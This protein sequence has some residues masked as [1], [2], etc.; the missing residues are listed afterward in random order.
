VTALFEFNDP[1]DSPKP[2]LAKS[3]ARTTDDPK[4]LSDL[5]RLCRVGR[6]YDV[7]RWIQA[8]R[9]LQ[10][11]SG[12]TAGQRR[13]AS[14]LEIALQAGNQSL[15]FLLLCN[16]YDPNLEVG[17][18]LDLM[19]CLPLAQQFRGRVR[20]KTDGTPAWPAQTSD[21]HARNR[22]HCPMRSIGVGHSTSCQMRSAMAAASASSA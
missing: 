5:H 17:S 6:L 1:R 19:A 12:G 3:A 15:V 7:E 8:G 10:A 14:A 21:R 20:G 22:W 16:G 18:P 13:V 4:D 11:I 2:A 9:P